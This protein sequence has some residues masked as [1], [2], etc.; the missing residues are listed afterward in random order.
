MIFSLIEGINRPA[1]ATSR[2]P[3]TEFIIKALGA[4]I[5]SEIAP[6]IK[7]PI[8]PAPIA[9]VTTPRT[10]PLSSALETS[11][12]IVDCMVPNPE[13]P[14]PKNNNT[15]SDRKYQLE[16][17]K[18]N[19]ATRDNKEPYKYILPWYFILL[20]DAIP[21]EPINAPNPSLAIKIPINKGP[22]F[23]ISLEITVT[24]CM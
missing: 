15:R 8:G 12:T 19:S 11:K 21:I 7:D 13:V 14:I 4:P 5:H 24:I 1:I 2:N 10:L 22:T 17:E 18:R 6:I 20:C 9:M 3:I 23:N 16:L